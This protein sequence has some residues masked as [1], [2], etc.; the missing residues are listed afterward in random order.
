MYQSFIKLLPT[1]KHLRVLDPFQPSNVN[2]P[3]QALRK[4]VINAFKPHT[5]V[6]PEDS[7]PDCLVCEDYD[8]IISNPPWKH[9]KQILKHLT[10]LGT[11]FALLLPHVVYTRKFFTDLFDINKDIQIV[12]LPQVTF[13]QRDQDS[14]II[15]FPKPFPGAL[16]F[17]CY[18]M[19]LPTNSPYYITFDKT[20]VMYM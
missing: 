12:M 18:N 6:I 7:F 16:D 5:L 9:K 17:V 11:P 2:G 19:N 20:K 13:L 15:P 1:N 10:D 14:N 4:D 3:L 8:C